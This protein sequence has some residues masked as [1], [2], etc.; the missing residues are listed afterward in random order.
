MYLLFVG[1]HGGTT[2][3]FITECHRQLENLYGSIQVE[4]GKLDSEQTLDQ[5]LEKTSRKRAGI[6]PLFYLLWGSISK[7]TKEYIKSELDSECF[8]ISVDDFNGSTPSRGFEDHR[9]IILNSDNYTKLEVLVKRLLDRF[10][11]E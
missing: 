10:K 5:F 2:R 9:V 6:P 8:V 3:D 4:I 11:M 7:D 1:N